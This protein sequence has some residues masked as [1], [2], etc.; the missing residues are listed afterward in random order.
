MAVKQRITYVFSILFIFFGCAEKSK[1]SDLKVYRYNEAVNVSSL[2]PAFAKSQNNM[3]AVNQIFDG[4]VAMDDSLNI[5]PRVA[6]SWTFSEDRKQIN[7][8]LNQEFYF[9]DDPCFENGSG[10]KLKAQDI[11]YSFHR[12]IDRNINSPGSWIFDGVIAEQEPFVA[13]SDSVFQLNLQKAFLPILGILSM[14][15]CGIVPEE[16]VD[17]YGNN[18][19]ANPVGTGPFKF[20]RWIENQ[21]LYLLKNEN[22]PQETGNLEGVKISFI[23]DKKIA[24]YALLNDKLDFFSG[25]ESS[26]SSEILENDGSLKEDKEEQINLVSAPFLNMEY[27]GINMELAKNSI[28]GSKKFRQALNYAI[29]RETMI[30]LLKSN[31]PAPATSGFVPR[32]LPSFNEKEV[33][34][35]TYNTSKATELLKSSNYD[36]NEIITLY[37]NND[38]ADIITYVA[39]SWEKIGVKVRIELQ[40]TSVLRQGMRNSAVPLFRASWIADY[41]DAESFLCMFYGENPPPPNYTRFNNSAFDDLYNQALSE[42]DTEKRYELYWQMDELIVEEAPVIFLYYDKTAI[43]TSKRVK[44]YRANALN[45]LDCRNI[46]IN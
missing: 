19:R 14:Q 8:L 30:S 43:F 17:Y 33:L 45:M 44:N 46:S 32:G 13:L 37:T 3:W 12:I 36:G 34:G 26:F 42:N 21:G 41:P 24:F 39:K 20:K 35:Y 22:Y 11:V 9:H 25:V 27:I 40:E 10:R 5:I 16:A 18:F 4:L 23:A 31:I 7:F 29:D 6:K 2:D 15:Y 38:Y 28:L 1:K